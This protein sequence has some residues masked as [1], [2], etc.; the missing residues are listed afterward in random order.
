MTAVETRKVLVV[1]DNPDS[2]A[3]L[4]ALLKLCGHE[5]EVAADGRAG[6]VKAL[7]WQP[8]VAV[9]DIGLPYLDGNEVAR[10]V[11]AALGADIRL[12]A[13]TAYSAPE[14]RRRAAEAGFD[15][16]LAKPADPD[17]LCRLVAGAG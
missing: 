12:I 7:D 13:L 4:Q 5:V 17:H 8:E 3:M 9:V 10:R 2:R 14:D 15:F 11:R 6:V 16:F 1:E